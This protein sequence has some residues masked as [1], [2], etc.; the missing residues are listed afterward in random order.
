[1]VISTY[2]RIK[3][4][5][6]T[7]KVYSKSWDVYNLKQYV[8]I[9]IQKQY[10]TLHHIKENPTAISRIQ[11]SDY[12]PDH[13]TIPWTHKVEKQHMEKIN[14]YST[15]LKSINNENFTSELAEKTHSP[16]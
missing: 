6:Y 7:K 3:T 15:N 11:E 10:N 5:T 8:L 4:T 1:M 12:L 2:P 13:C 16:K 9:Q 14:H